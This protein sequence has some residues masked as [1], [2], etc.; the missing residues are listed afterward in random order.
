MCLGE[1]GPRVSV[2]R[3][4]LVHGTQCIL[5]KSQRSVDKND[6]KR[7]GLTG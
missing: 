1:V 6:S 2:P 4:E 5:G 7:V 3:K